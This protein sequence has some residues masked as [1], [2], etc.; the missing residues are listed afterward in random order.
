VR[1]AHLASPYQGFDHGQLAVWGSFLHRR[2]ITKLVNFGKL[3]SGGIFDGSGLH[4]SWLWEQRNV[5]PA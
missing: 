4:R 2:I 1:G 3:V 5:Q